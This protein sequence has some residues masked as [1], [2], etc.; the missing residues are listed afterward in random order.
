MAT[1]AL[2]IIKLNGDNWSTWK[3]DLS[4]ALIVQGLAH[5]LLPFPENVTGLT[6]TAA[7]REARRA[8]YQRDAAKVRA[9]MLMAMDGTRALQWDGMFGTP[10]EIW[11]GLHTIY[12]AESKAS[13][14][15]LINELSDLRMLPKENING[16]IGRVTELAARLRYADKAKSDEEIC[17]YLLK[18]LPPAFST[19]R[20][21][22][23][24]SSQ[25]DGLTLAKV[26]PILLNAEA[27]MRQLLTASLEFAPG[28]PSLPLEQ[29]QWRQLKGA[30]VGEVI[31]VRAITSALTADLTRQREQKHAA[32]AAE[33]VGKAAE[34]AN[35]EV[36]VLRGAFKRVWKSK[37]DN[38]LKEVFFRIAGH[39][40]SG[41]RVPA[42]TCPC[43]PGVVLG[44]ANSRV[45][46]FWICPVAV[47]IRAE[48]E[49][50][51]QQPVSRPEVWLLQPPAARVRPEIWDL[52]C[53][54]ALGAMEHGRRLG[55]ARHAEQQ[56]GQ[57]V[58][59]EAVARFWQ[60]L[61]SC[62]SPSLARDL[63]SQPLSSTHPFLCLSEGQLVL[64]GQPQL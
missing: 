49:R 44:A 1:A 28:A 14:L 50:V 61:D 37:V 46:S 8:A 64:K 22:L 34:T 56:Q 19:V 41:G 47:A 10:H 38:R 57:P 62:I 35:E 63:E 23:T 40:I 53:L 48:L 20:T 2:T 33:A 27:E 42:W 18:G 55:W 9:L 16:Y 17:V 6:E 60:L 29:L 52:V 32:F 21:V 45:H 11:N 15:K 24:H 3:L 58:A 54:A 51:L 43:T 7:Q 26:W 5:C 39:A 4:N 25:A 13:Y 31:P 12:K 30:S 36:V 59:L